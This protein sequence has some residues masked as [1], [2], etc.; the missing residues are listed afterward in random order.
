MLVDR[1]CLGY[2]DVALGRK[3]AVGPDIGPWAGIDGSATGV[4]DDVRRAR[5]VLNV[6]VAL[7]DD[8]MDIDIRATLAEDNERSPE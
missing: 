7:F 8:S 2:E 4:K 1:A 6:F 3:E 5:N